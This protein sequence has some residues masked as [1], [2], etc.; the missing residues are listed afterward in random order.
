[1]SISGMMRWHQSIKSTILLEVNEI[2]KISKLLKYLQELLM[3]F[4]IDQIGD[5]LKNCWITILWC[6]HSNAGATQNSI[7]VAQVL[8]ILVFFIRNI[9]QTRSFFWTCH[10]Q[11]ML[12]I[13]GA[14]A[15]IGSIGKDKFGEEMKK[16]A[17]EA[18]VN[19][20]IVNSSIYLNY[21]DHPLLD[22]NLLCY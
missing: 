6:Y 18:G 10:F 12:Q 9:L 2:K 3:K 11:W 17:K 13:P 22:H 20:S 19:V 5:I 21:Y 8:V 1:M 7:R 15:F 16:N 4:K 14:T